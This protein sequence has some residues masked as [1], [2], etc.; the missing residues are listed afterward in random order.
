MIASV[1]SYSYSQYIRAGKMTQFDCLKK[2][3]EMGFEAIE[4]I[5][6][7]GAGLDEQKKNA[8]KYRAESEAIGL[9]IAAYT[10][11]A[12]LYKETKEERDAEVARLKNEVDIAELLGAK[13]MRHDVTYSLTKTFPGRSFDGQLPYIA[14]GAR[15]VTEYAAA[16]GIRTC[17]ENH[18][19]IAQDSDRVERLVNAVCH[20]NYGLLVD[21]GNFICV[22]ENPITAV[23]RVAP[24]AFH[25]HVKDFRIRS[26][27][28]AVCK[29]QTRGCNYF[30]GLPVGEGNVP[31]KQCLAILKKAGYDGVV[32]IEY[33]GVEDCIAGIARGKANLD[34]YI[35]EL[36]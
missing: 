32:S 6:I 25:V 12:S 27:P 36:A 18:G 19:H 30:V 9:P 16:K 14:E 8:E 7:D 15:A 1:S 5:E 23:S 2:A 24:Y 22:D 31:V 26:T 3:K 11:G 17:T 20:D 28:D 29:G 35:A 4:F 33:E 21:V 10:I 13:V 34:R